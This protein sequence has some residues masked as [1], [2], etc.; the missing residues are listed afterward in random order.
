[1]RTLLKGGTAVLPEG[2]RRCDILAEDGRI[3]RIAPEI[4]PWDFPGCREL[5][6]R[7]KLI[8]PG[9]VDAHVHFTPATADD[10]SAGSRAAAW[11]GVTTVIGYAGP[12]PGQNLMEGLERKMGEARGK[13]WT[14]YTFHAEILGWHRAPPEDLRLVREA[15]LSSLKIYTTYGPDRLDDAEIRTLLR[16]AA[17]E[18]LLL[19][20]HAEDDGI[21]AAATDALAGEGAIPWERFPDARPAG[22]ETAMV[23]KLAKMAEETGGAVHIVHVSTAASAEI[24]ASARRQGVHITGETCPQYLALTRECYTRPDAPEFFVTPPMRERAD[25]AGLWRALKEGTLSLVTTDHCAY[26]PEVKAEAGPRL[27][28]CP[29]LPGVETLLPL[30]FTL[31]V[32]EKRISLENLVRLTSEHPARLFGLYPRKGVIAEG[33][34]ADLVVLDPARKSEL[35]G[36]TLHSNAGYTPYEGWK[37]YG[38]PEYVMARGALL[39]EGGVWRGAFPAGEFVPAGAWSAPET[40]G[41]NI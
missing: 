25:C 2:I 39:V 28:A 23:E 19:T 38:V 12:R 40:W 20:V 7:G 15:G 14:D 26:P 29:G 27:D 6:C 4:D 11:G 32:H 30:L 41:E 34:D 5:S 21:C 3:A 33:S 17:D 18:G 36:E 8:L 35:R 37:V 16:H 9:L 10:F 24:I 1:M 22:A 31:G 13:S